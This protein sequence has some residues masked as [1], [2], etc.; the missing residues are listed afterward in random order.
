MAEGLLG[1]LDAGDHADP[2]GL[3]AGALIISL[4]LW[5]IQ[6]AEWR[7]SIVA[8][9][10]SDGAT[11]AWAAARASWLVILTPIVAGALVVCLGWGLVRLIGLVEPVGRLLLDAA[12]LGIA[13]ADWLVGR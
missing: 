8:G 11:L 5:L 3:H 1:A 6:P 12:H 13:G 2:D 7:R 4:F 10:Q 9:L